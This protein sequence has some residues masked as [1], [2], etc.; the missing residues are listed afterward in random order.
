LRAQ[1]WVGARSF[2]QLIKTN[3]KKYGLIGVI[4]GSMARECLCLCWFV[5]ELCYETEDFD[6]CGGFDCVR[7]F[8][9]L[10]LSAFLAEADSG[11]AG[12]F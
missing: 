11:S 10:S 6:C 9:D 2:N 8:F 1:G 5:V 7:G 3:I 4:F 12:E